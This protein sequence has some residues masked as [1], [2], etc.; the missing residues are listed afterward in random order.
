M[1]WGDAVIGWANVALSGGKLDVTLGYA[2]RCPQ[3][4]AF[5]RAL[6]AELAR[7]EHF[8]KARKRSGTVEDRAGGT[9]RR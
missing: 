3:G 9:D 5:R 2:E 6:D 1:L 4:Q 8:L 7:M